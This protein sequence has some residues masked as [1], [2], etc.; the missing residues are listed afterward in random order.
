MKFGLKKKEIKLIQLIF[1]KYSDINKVFIYGS[2]VNKNYKK[3]SDIDLAISFNPNK[4]NAM[5]KIKSD[6]D[7][8]S[9][10]YGIDATNEAEIIPGNFRDEYEKT[11]KIFYIKNN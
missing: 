6:L 4:N 1:K 8:L 11:K 3:T 5:A 2:R 7:D 10:I 9:I